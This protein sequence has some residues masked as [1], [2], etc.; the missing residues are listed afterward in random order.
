MG[1]LGPRQ[2]FL[3]R[4]IRIVPPQNRGEA[5]HVVIAEE[6]RHRQ[7]GLF[8]AFIQHIAIEQFVEDVGALVLA[9]HLANALLEGEV[10]HGGKAVAAGILRDVAVVVVVAVDL[11]EDMEVRD[12]AFAGCLEHGGHEGLPELR[13]DVARGID[14]EAIDAGAADPVRIDI[15]HAFQH[16]G[17]FGEEIV[18]PDEVAEAAAFAGKSRVAAIMVIDRIVEPG[19]DFHIALCLGNHGGIGVIGIAQLGEIRVAAVLVTHEAGVDRF[20]VDRSARRIGIIAKTAIG[21]SGLVTFGIADHVGGVV[22]DD[23]H[24]DLH[25]ARVGSIDEGLEL[26]ARTEMAVRTREVGHPI[27]VIARALVPFGPL[28]GLVLEDGR[29]PDCRDAEVFQIIETLRQPLQVTAVEEAL[30]RRVEARLQPAAGEIAEVIGSVAVLEAVRQDEID[31]FL[32][33]QAVAKALFGCDRCAF[34]RGLGAGA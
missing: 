5:P 8:P 18:E 11:A 31:D 28:D 26:L 34:Q 20:S 13:I 30:V 7:C 10:E 21:I 9:H 4:D 12:A 16:A 25:P 15:D 33:R 22:G 2:H 32:A 27:S 14:A 23:V 24:V 3:V 1:E 6:C 29:E 19:G 17:V